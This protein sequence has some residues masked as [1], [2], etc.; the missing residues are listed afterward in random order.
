MPKL[1]IPI[2]NGY[3]QS[4]SLPISSQRCINWYP[5]I[6]QAPA[7]AQETLL[8]TPGILGLTTT[9]TVKQQNRGGF[10]FQGNPYIVNGENLYRITRSGDTYTAT[11]LGAIPGTARVSMAENGTQLCILVPGGN[12]Y[13]FTTGPDTLTQITDADFTANGN[14]QFVVFLDGYFV[15]TTDEKKFIISSLN[16]GLSY[17]A[18]DFG[19]A[20]ADPDD[21]VAPVVLRNQL[22][23]IGKTTTEAFQNIGGAAF[24]FQRT[25]LFLSK[26]A[27]SPYSVVVS[28]DTFMMLGGG[29][30]E[31]PAIWAF[32]GNSFTKISTTAIESELIG[33]DDAFL[34]NAFAWSYAQ[35]GAYF[36]GFT[37]VDT[38]FVF[39][40]I[41][42][43]WHERQSRYTDGDIMVTASRVSSVMDAFGELI[44]ADRIDG[45]VGRLTTDEYQEYG[46]PIVRSISTQPFANQGNAAFV[47]QLELTVESGVGNTD[48]PDPKMTLERSTDGGKT[49]TDPR[50]RSIGKIGEYEKRVIWYRNG[51]ASRFETFRFVLTDAVKP[52]IIKAEALVSGGTK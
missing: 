18:L 27:K 22:F 7:L 10:V 2:A 48:A 38:T 37:F 23:I 43:R 35:K 29:E 49:W 4:S 41:S 13:I 33:L 44:V 14:P 51:R 39:D 9:G 19:S 15:F 45:G 16:D 47:P 34:S 26:G 32:A 8:G 50:A 30:R 31:A 21:I 17:N 25:G 5:N 42:Q 1:P 46:N 24:P 52:V 11:D 3:Y 36:V 28:N 40:T 12:G 6:V 20:E